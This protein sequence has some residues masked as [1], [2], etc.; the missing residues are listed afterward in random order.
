MRPQVESLAARN[1]ITST[2]VNH[3]TGQSSN[4]TDYLHQVPVFGGEFPQVAD[5]STSKM[6]IVSQLCHVLSPWAK[7][8]YNVDR[9]I[10]DAIGEIGEESSCSTRFQQEAARTL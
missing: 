6:Q 1:D 3:V 8:V 2:K 10:T 9:G 5:P 7:R 4:A